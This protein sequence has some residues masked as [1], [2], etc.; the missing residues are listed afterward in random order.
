MEEGDSISGLP[1]LNSLTKSS[2]RCFSL[3]SGSS[4]LCSG[5][6]DMLGPCVILSEDLNFGGS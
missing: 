6:K 1:A 5:A 2:S 3:N 4:L